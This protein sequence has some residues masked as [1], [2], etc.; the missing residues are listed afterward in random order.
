MSLVLFAAALLIVALIVLTASGHF[1]AEHRR[2]GHAV[3]FASLAAAFA[4][5]IV[6]LAFAWNRIPWYA[7]V[8]AGGLPVLAAPLV[9][10]PLPDRFVDGRASL[11][12]FS[13]IAVALAAAMLGLMQR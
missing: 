6:S 5:L 3:L 7:A 11:V 4:C 12:I 1:P 13:A 9:L 8:I 10:R 2:V